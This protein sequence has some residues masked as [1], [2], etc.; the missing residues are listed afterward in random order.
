[1]GTL[2]DEWDLGISSSSP[3]RLQADRKRG[4]EQPRGTQGFSFVRR[5][6]RKE[7]WS[8][9]TRPSVGHRTRTKEHGSQ[10]DK[11]DTLD[12]RGRQEDLLSSTKPPFFPPTWQGQ[13]MLVRVT[14]CHLT[15]FG[16]AYLAGITLA[17]LSGIQSCGQPALSLS[18]P[19]DRPRHGMLS[20]RQRA[21]V[22]METG[23]CTRLVLSSVPCQDS[24][25]MDSST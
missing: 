19:S 2:G 11:N 24:V 10:R 9:G 17:G 23:G 15:Q 1:M 14:G 6:G 25:F 21:L 13:R 20:P 12:L 7:V 18:L 8:L 22:S 3:S 5:W 16:S 4:T